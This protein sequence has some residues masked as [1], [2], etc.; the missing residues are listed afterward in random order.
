MTFRV[1]DP[2]PPS[3]VFLLPFA[4]QF[5]FIYSMVWVT[6]CL[7][8]AGAVVLSSLSGCLICLCLHLFLIGSSSPPFCND[9]NGAVVIC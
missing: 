7:M 9:F 2:N 4:F 5:H 3:S 6:V 1:V 8:F